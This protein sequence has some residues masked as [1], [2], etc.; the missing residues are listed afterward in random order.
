MSIRALA[1][2]LYRAQQRV[3]RLQDRLE[4]ASI[5]DSD[6]LRHELRQAE[7]VCRQ[8]RRLMDGEKQPSSFSGNPFKK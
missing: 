6:T 8:L 3:H 4:K 5:N 7:A 2:E 1:I